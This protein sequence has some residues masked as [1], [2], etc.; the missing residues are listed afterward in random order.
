MVKTMAF[1]CTLL[2]FFM[3]FGGFMVAG[4]EIEIFPGCQLRLALMAF[5][6]GGMLFFIP[7]LLIKEKRDAKKRNFIQS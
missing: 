6:V 4:M 7:A 3:V 5:A 2:F 1:I